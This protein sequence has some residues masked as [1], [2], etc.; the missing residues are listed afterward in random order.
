MIMEPGSAGPR[1]GSVSRRDGGSR[2]LR[3]PVGRHLGSCET[4]QGQRF[5]LG[6]VEDRLLDCRCQEGQLQMD[7]K[8]A[9]GDAVGLREGLVRGTV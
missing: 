1:A 2:V 3:G 6:A 4:V 9:F 8:A 5:G 7:A